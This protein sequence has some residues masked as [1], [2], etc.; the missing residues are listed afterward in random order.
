MKVK[1]HFVS[2][3]VLTGAKDGHQFLE[4]LYELRHAFVVRN[5]CPATHIFLSVPVQNKLMAVVYSYLSPAIEGEIMGL[6]IMTS[7]DD[8]NFI[9]LL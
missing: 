2:T 3:E 8:R 1:E 6:T 5:G 7:P 4:I 9:A